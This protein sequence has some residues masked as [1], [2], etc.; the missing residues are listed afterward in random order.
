MKDLF[1]VAF[2]VR[3]G[4]LPKGL[5]EQVAKIVDKTIPL[6]EKV[7][8]AYVSQIEKEVKED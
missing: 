1:E 2:V 4:N 3:A 5:T 8:K 7:A 6:L